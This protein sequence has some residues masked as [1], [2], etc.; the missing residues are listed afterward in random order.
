M[1]AHHFSTLLEP[2]SERL[3]L[4][5]RI[6]QGYFGALDVECL[7]DEPL[8]AELDAYKVGPLNM[9]MID[10]PAH[11]VSRSDLRTEIP[12]DEVFKL[13][14]QLE[15][16]ADIRQRDRVFRL[17]PGDWSLYDPRVPYSITNH[18]RSRLL[19]ITIPRQQFKG[20]KMP[21][22]HT[23]EAQT[24]SMRGLNAVLGSFLTSLVEQLPSLPNGV[25]Q[26]VGDTVLGLLASTLATQKDERHGAMQMPSVF[27]ARV[28]QFVHAHLADSDLSLDLIAQELRCSKRY[29]HRVFED[30]ELTLDRF[31]WLTRLERCADALR[32]AVGRP[33][34]VSEI[35]FAWGFNSSAHFCR[36][37]KAHF[38][39]SPRDFQ[40]REL[41]AASARAAHVLHH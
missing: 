4:W 18:E 17:H 32:A 15:G 21:E 25:G 2:A 8:N 31:I 6:N 27:K 38:G 13:V 1:D 10:A 22:L 29:L 39:V 5:G 40:R 7:H 16:R 30:E 14:L 34:S 12:L 24:P 37:F 26:P 3:A 23:C 9:F 35:A 28:K 11:R 41:A 19:A 36:L 33:S 20:I